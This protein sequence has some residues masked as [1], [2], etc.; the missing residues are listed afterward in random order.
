MLL[1]ALGLHVQRHACALRGK[2]R[3]QKHRPWPSATKGTW[4]AQ[5]ASWSVL[6]L[7]SSRVLRL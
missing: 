3:T 1:P 6:E 5:K 2:E 4:N 7:V